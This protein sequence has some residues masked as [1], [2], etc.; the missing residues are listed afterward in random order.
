MALRRASLDPRGDGGDLRYVGRPTDRLAGVVVHLD[1]RRVVD[2]VDG[3]EGQ[4]HDHRR[5]AQRHRRDRDPA[6]VG[7]EVDERLRA[8]GKEERVHPHDVVRL[9]AG[10]DEHDRQKGVEH[11]EQTEPGIA[12]RDGPVPT[13]TRVRATGS[14]GRAGTARTPGGTRRFPSHRPRWTGSPR[15]A[16][17]RSRPATPDTASPPRRPH[18]HRPTATPSGAGPVWSR[19]R[20]GPGL[21]AGTTSRRCPATRTRPSPLR[22]ATIGRHLRVVPAST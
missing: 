20:R 13:P 6:P 11:P 2:S 21:R 15:A 16:A 14:P 17:S 4:D 9:P 8:G 5:K 18:R 7:E 10:D 3:N 1:D 22:P 19:G 12:R